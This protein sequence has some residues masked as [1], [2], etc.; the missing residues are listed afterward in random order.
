MTRS[1]FRFEGFASRGGTALLSPE[2]EG[3]PILFTAVDRT[4]PVGG[5]GVA[6]VIAAGSGRA[7]GSNPGGIDAL[8]GANEPFDLRSGVFAAVRADALRLEVTGYRDGEAVVTR[9][10]E[11]DQTAERI[12]FGREFRDLDLVQFSP[13]GGGG[14]LFDPLADNFFA[15][16][17][18]AI[19]TTDA[20][21]FG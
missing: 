7:A 2:T 15:V 14:S 10:F 17:N 4:A 1:V 11:L 21:P 6:N 18:L 9:T 16:D 3:F 12:R 20:D 8:F 5:D 19:R 13:S